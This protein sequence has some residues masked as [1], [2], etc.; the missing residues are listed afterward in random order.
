MARSATSPTTSG[1]PTPP[2]RRWRRALARFGRHLIRYNA[3]RAF[4]GAAVALG[5]VVLVG[6]DSAVGQGALVVVGTL[7]SYIL[8]PEDPSRFWR[9]QAADLADTVP[10]SDLRKAGRSTAQ[11]LALQSGGVVGSECA[12]LMWDDAMARVGLAV[13]DPLRVVM[14]MDYRIS[15][16][17]DAGRQLVRATITAKRCWPARDTVFFSF[18]SDV[19]ALSREFAATGEGSI[20]REIVDPHLSETLDAWER[21]VAAYPVSLVIDGRNY[22]ATRRETLRFDGRSQ[23]Q[24]VIFDVSDSAIRERMTPIRLTSEFHIP[25]DEQTYTVK[26]STY[27]CVGPTQL[28]LEVDDATAEIDAN[29]FLRSPVAESSFF[30][31]YGLASHRVSLQL[32]STAVLHP[33]SGVVFSWRPGPLL[34][35]PPV[36]LEG[37]IGAGRPLPADATMPKALL[38]CESLDEPMVP[39]RSVRCVDAY[40]HLGIVDAPRD[41]VAREQVVERLYQAQAGLP[42]GFSFVVLD[43]WRDRELQ[44]A[45][46]DHY[47]EELGGDLNGYVADPMSTTMRPPHVVGGALDL[48]LAYGGRP[49]ALG[50][51]YDE[52]ADVAHFDAFESADS[53][54][55]RL[56]RLMAGALLDAGFAPLPTEWWHWSYGDDVWAAFYGHPASLYDVDGSGVP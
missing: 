6:A 28:S 52:F 44:A 30:H 47:K 45:L 34:A 55:R 36:T 12:G 7:I 50:S 5:V 2:D 8:L 54:V 26:F 10:P 29:D 18:C 31:Q 20:S 53:L 13:V 48:T 40:H 1:P 39:L 35:R 3:L 32:G 19:E 16:S 43:A 15:V 51:E 4:A 46:V 37:L 11:A 49:L 23:A 38:P 27:F 41:L 33:G 14:D 21:R 56:R 9:V 22:E 42:A 24:R 17:R 25:P